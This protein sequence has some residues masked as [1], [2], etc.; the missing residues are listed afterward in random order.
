[1]IK[2]ASS[3]NLTQ[4]IVCRNND[5]NNTWLLIVSAATT[6]PTYTRKCRPM[7]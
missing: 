5:Y 3:L 6:S 4:L 7:H 2:V 1:M